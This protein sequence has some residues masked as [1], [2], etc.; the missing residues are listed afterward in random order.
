MV[1]DTTTRTYYRFNKDDRSLAADTPDSKFITQEKSRCVLGNWTE[2]VAGIGKGSITRGE[3]PTV[4][5]SNT[6]ASKAS[7]LKLA[8][9]YNKLTRG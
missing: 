7:M 8:Y 4:F 5:K 3:G 2:V 6:V 9:I 1:L